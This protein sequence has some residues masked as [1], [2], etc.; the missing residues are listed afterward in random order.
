MKISNQISI[1]LVFLSLTLA[2][3]IFAQNTWIGGTPGAEND[4]NNPQNWSLNRVPDDADLVVIVADVSTQSGFFPI[5]K[6]VVPEIAFLNIE[7]G[8]TLTILNT[9]KLIVNGENT[10][11]YGI[12][13]TGTILNAGKLIIE[14]TAL[15]P[16]AEAKNN[17]IN[18][19]NF[20]FMAIDT[21]VILADN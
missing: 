3:T 10:F 18:T 12:Q 5:V 19:G 6:N 4:W 2:Q 9:G 1:I 13:N 11:N 7:G 17:I 15:S 8:A 14:K 16:L 21:E 20:A